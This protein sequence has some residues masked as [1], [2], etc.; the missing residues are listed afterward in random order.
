MGDPPLYPNLDENA[1]FLD[2]TKELN[3]SSAEK[4][5]LQLKVDPSAI[6]SVKN[7]YK[8][9]S[10]LHAYHLLQAWYKNT[11][12]NNTECC[13]QLGA[14]FLKIGRPVEAQKVDPEIK[15]G[16]SNTSNEPETRLRKRKSDESTACMSVF[17]SICTNMPN[18]VPFAICV[19]SQ[20]I[21]NNSPYQ[22]DQP[23]SKKSKPCQKD[24]T[25]KLAL[26]PPVKNEKLDAKKNKR[27]DKKCSV[28]CY[29]KKVIEGEKVNKPA[30]DKGRIKY[31][32]NECHYFQW[33]ENIS[34]E[35]HCYHGFNAVITKP[36][37]NVY[38]CPHVHNKCRY[39]KRCSTPPNQMKLLF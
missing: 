29:C 15:V 11:T 37:D 6:L 14:A 12:N 27:I 38:N 34:M 33:K 9:D 25:L 24:N 28:L 1:F 21:D 5:A 32:C 31:Y 23:L 4:L 3:F 39:S 16:P 7:K 30:S 18:T 17:I 10:N 26:L 36:G 19:L 35:Y 8:D 13:K 22:E 20:N 2:L